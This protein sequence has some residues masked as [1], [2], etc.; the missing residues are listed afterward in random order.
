MIKLIGIKKNKLI[1]GLVL[2]DPLIK[3]MGT[4]ASHKLNHH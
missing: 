4:A 2:R 3:I 1:K